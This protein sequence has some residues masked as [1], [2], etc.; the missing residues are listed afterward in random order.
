MIETKKKR[1][2]LFS[3]FFFTIFL[4]FFLNGCAAGTRDRLLRTFIDGVPDQNQKT[5]KTDSLNRTGAVNTSESKANKSIELKNIVHPPFAEQM[6]DSCHESKFSQRL[7]QKGKA[8]CFTCHD[9][10]SDKKKTVHYPVSEDLCLECHEPHQAPN[11]G[12]L[13]KKVP[14]ICWACHDDFA[15]G[16]DI[17]VVHP[18]VEEGLCLECHDPHASDNERMLKQPVP[19]LCYTCHDQKSIEEQPQ[20]KGKEKCLACH[21]IHASKKEKLLK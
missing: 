9:D 1:S 2:T 6:C 17:K 12:L 16:K 3:A 18:P 21:E 19:A 20:H 15:K 13:K 11:K 10:F 8:L 4:S 14:E 5:K 7:S